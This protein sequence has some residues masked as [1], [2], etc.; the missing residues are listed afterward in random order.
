MT[1][2]E[3]RAPAAARG[4]VAPFE[5]VVAEH[6]AVVLRVCRAVLDLHDA[7]DA[8]SAAFLSALEAYPSLPADADVRAWLVTIARRKAIDIVR[9]RARHAVPVA[10]P[11][12]RESSLGVPGARDLDLAAA[13]AGL[14]DRQRAAVS[15]HHLGGLPH[16]EVAEL[17]ASSETAVRRA[18]SDGIR[19]LR[20]AL[21][22][23]SAERG[24]PSAR[25]RRRGAEE[26]A[27]STASPPADRASSSA[28]PH[29]EPAA[30]T[31]PRPEEIR[32]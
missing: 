17:T 24:A 29:E 8:W 23:G 26:P 10:E 5:R 28:P 25:R 15:L 22:V 16:R 27:A 20:A 13:I 1:R 19:S 32:P 6:G 18:A 14:P 3:R 30:S 7:E 31:A 4:P 12:E 11:P 21:G 9:A 2:A